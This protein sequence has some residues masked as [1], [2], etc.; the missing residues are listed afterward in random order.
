MSK[1][2]IGSNLFQYNRKCTQC[3]LVA[4]LSSVNVSKLICLIVRVHG[5][6]IQCWKW[7]TFPNAYCI[8]VPFSVASSLHSVNHCINK[9]FGQG[10]SFF[11]RFIFGAEA[12]ILSLFLQCLHRHANSWSTKTAVFKPIA[13]WDIIYHFRENFWWESGTRRL[14]FAVSWKMSADTDPNATANRESSQEDL[15]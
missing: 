14:S 13:W 9:G 15:R 4:S 6:W 7:L 2:D 3:K 5:C 1:K 11:L 8:F 10:S 12:I